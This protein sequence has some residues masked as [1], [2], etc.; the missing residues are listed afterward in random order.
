MLVLNIMSSLK[1]LSKLLGVSIST[2]SKALN[3]AD[4]ISAHTKKRVKELALALNYQPNKMGAALRNKKSKTIGVIIPDILNPFFAE[5][6]FGIEKYCSLK[7]YDTLVCISNDLTS[8]E[9]E[10]IKLLKS[11]SVDGFLI[12]LASQTQI[13]QDYTHIIKNIPSNELVLFDRLTHHISCDKV[14]VDDENITY[15]T[16]KNLI[17]NGRKSIA[18]LSTIEHLEIGKERKQGYQKALKEAKISNNKN[19]E[20]SLETNAVMHNQIKEWILSN[21]FDAVIAADNTSGIIVQNFL[22]ALKP[23]KAKKIKVIG[24]SN[25][26][27]SL[28]T[29]PQL[30]YIDQNAELIGQKAAELLINRIQNT[31][32]NKAFT[33]IKIPASII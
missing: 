22:L 24:F 23:I 20:L 7:G 10:K 32:K 11:G 18:F 28:L 26:N 8:K 31:N 9:A 1:E 15:K 12:S 29:F 21:E 19:L 3:N 27:Q 13:N 6:L 5:V 2:V 33:H 25:A 14:S 16:T 30:S 17:K 4:D